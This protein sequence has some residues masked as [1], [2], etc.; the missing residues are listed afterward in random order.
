MRTWSVLVPGLAVG[1]ISLAPVGAVAEPSSEADELRER[2]GVE[3]EHVVAAPYGGAHSEPL[4]RTLDH[5]G[6]EVDAAVLPEARPEQHRGFGSFERFTAA[7]AHTPRHWRQRYGHPGATR[8]GEAVEGR[9]HEG[10][11]RATEARQLGVRLPVALR[12][13]RHGAQCQVS[14]GLRRGLEEAG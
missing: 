8:G 10:Q 12:H 5:R 9:Q 4:D 3:L 1:L 6:A 7:H 2:V 11:R 13:P 14:D